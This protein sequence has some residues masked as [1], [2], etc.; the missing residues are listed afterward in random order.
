MAKFLFLLAFLGAFLLSTAEIVK[1][2]RKDE[3]VSKFVEKQ[4][5]FAFP[6]G[7]ELF[8]KGTAG[9]YSV[10]DLKLK[11]SPCGTDMANFNGIIAYSNG[12]YQGTGYSCSGLGFNINALNILSV[13][14][15][16]CMVLHLFGQ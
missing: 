11:A 13:I 5:A 4:K 9:N 15:T 14:S 3:D 16:T 12:E 8:P 1:N 6:K 10:P 7:A 2:L